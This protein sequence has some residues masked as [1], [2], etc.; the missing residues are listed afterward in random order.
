[1]KVDDDWGYTPI[2]G[3]LHMYTIP[4]DLKDLDIDINKPSTVRVPGIFQRALQTRLC[5]VKSFANG[6][7]ELRTFSKNLMCRQFKGHCPEQQQAVL[8]VAM[9]D[10]C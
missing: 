4:K 5:Y 8:E 6:S 3:S 9:T 7:A 10:L 1:M 2:L